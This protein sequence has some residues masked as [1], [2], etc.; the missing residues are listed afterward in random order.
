MELA[1]SCTSSAFEF[2]ASGGLFILPLP[3]LMLCS[4]SFNLWIVQNK[5]FK[6]YVGAPTSLTQWSYFTYLRTWVASRTA[7]N[8]A[9]KK[10]RNR[11]MACRSSHVQ[12][13][14][15]VC[16]CTSVDFDSQLK[17]TWRRSRM[18]QEILFF[19]PFLSQRTKEGVLHEKGSIL[20]WFS[21]V[22][23][24]PLSK[25]A[26]FST[27]RSDISICVLS[28][29]NCSERHLQTSIHTWVFSEFLRKA[30]EKRRKYSK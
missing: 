28:A 24:I 15:Q 11:D 16:R 5:Q 27:Y 10:G 6:I 3:F 26:W 12:F 20:W 19:W 21:F 2:L 17:P 23:R 9:E 1:K 25:L 29:D 14:E 18:L 7:Y 22:I 4:C 13:R 30:N 8:D